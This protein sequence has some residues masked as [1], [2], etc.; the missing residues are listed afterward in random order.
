M[1]MMNPINKN[2][3]KNFNEIGFYKQNPREDINTG[4]FT[5]D[6]QRDSFMNPS[7]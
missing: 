7:G 3:N 2:Q 1:N 6:K 4:N 5:N